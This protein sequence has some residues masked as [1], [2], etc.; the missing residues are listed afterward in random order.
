MAGFPQSSDCVAVL[1]RAFGWL[2][3]ATATEEPIMRKMLTDLADGWAFLAENR[4]REE[5]QLRHQHRRGSNGKPSAR[6]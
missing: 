1:E 2:A 4:K 5:K 6:W 3:K